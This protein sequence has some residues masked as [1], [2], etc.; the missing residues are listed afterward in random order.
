MMAALIAHLDMAADCCGCDDAM[1]GREDIGLTADF[2][3]VRSMPATG[4]LGV[5]AVNGP[6]LEGRNS[7]FDKTTL[8]QRV[9]VDGDLHVHV[10]RDREAAIDG[11]RR[12]TPIF[13]QLQAARPSLDLLNETCCRACVAFAENAEVHGKGTCAQPPPPAAVRGSS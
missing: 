13:V 3:D 10:I 4:A 7:A 2:D 5:K 12:R 6:A 1:R 9:G 8:V 11:S